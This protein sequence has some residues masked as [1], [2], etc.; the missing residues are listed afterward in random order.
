MKRFP[1]QGD[2]AWWVSD[3]HPDKAGAHPRGTI[4][5]EEAEAVYVEYAKR[6][7]ASARGQSL[8]RLRERGGFSYNEA[9]MLLGRPLETWLP[10][11]K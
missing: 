9:E 3:G 4:T 11:E 1:M 2:G 7:P 5:W 8:A 10:L 6:W